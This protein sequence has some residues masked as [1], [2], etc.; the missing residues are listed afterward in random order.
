ME[1]GGLKQELGIISTACYPAI[2]IGFNSTALSKP[3]WWA[4]IAQPSAN[5]DDEL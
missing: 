1:V 4:L 3:G 5:Q 2:Q